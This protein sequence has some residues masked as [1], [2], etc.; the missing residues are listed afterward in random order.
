M[1][2]L[3]TL[4]LFSVSTAFSAEVVTMGSRKPVPWWKH[5][6][7]HLVLVARP[8][9]RVFA[10]GGK[11]IPIPFGLDQAQFLPNTLEIFRLSPSVRAIVYYGSR[12]HFDYGYLPEPTSDLDLL[13]LHDGAPIADTYA[14]KGTLLGAHFPV[15]TLFRPA[16]DLEEAFQSRLFQFPSTREED[17][18]LHELAHQK[19]SGWFFCSDWK[20]SWNHLVA[21]R[22]PLTLE[23]RL[24][25]G[26]VGHAA[27]FSKPP[28][29][30]AVGKQA[31][32]FMRRS[33]DTPEVLSLLRKAGFSSIAI[34]EEDGSVS[35][36]GSVPRPQD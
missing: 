32:I 31:V 30:L 14:P 4:L 11:R 26:H 34:V 16:P 2:A 18:R 23:G 33:S 19:A 27:M 9:P 29:I 13:V 21:E 24:A 12:T 3:C 17:E 28:V 10:Q 20:I 35:I 22:N 6:A 5:C 8:E 7:R 36:P 1:K 25:T 15:H